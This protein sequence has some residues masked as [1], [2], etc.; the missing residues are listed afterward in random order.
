[1]EY[2]VEIGH[3]TWLRTHTAKYNVSS[4]GVMPITLDELLKLGEPG[5]PGSGI[6]K[7]IHH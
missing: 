3:F 2:A 7:P 4:S 1:M 5:D 6:N